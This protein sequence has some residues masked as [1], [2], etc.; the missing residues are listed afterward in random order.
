VADIREGARSVFDDGLQV[1]HQ[2]IDSLEVVFGF[3]G[4]GV[5]GTI[6]GATRSPVLIVLAPEPSRRKNQALFKSV[7]LEDAS[8]PFSLS[9][10]VPGL[11]SI[12]AFE[13]ASVNDETL[14]YL[15]PNFLSQHETRGVTVSVEKGAVVGP[16]QVPL[17]PR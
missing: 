6:K 17:I 8:K 4:A 3:D 1:A 2:P 13:L 7:V 15:H 10:V 9:E 14:R 11:Y 16:L 12:L 5:T